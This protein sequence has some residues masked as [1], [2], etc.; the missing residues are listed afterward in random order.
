MSPEG[1]AHAIDEYLR[2]LQAQSR[3]AE[4]FYYGR[5]GE[6]I[7]G[8]LSLPEDIRFKIEQLIWEAAGGKA[9]DLTDQASGN[10]VAESILF[11]LEERMGMHAS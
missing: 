6:G 4:A 1:I 8:L 9:I 11:S 7:E 2:A 3:I 10:L 5:V